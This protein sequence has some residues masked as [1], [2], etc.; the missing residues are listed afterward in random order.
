MLSDIPNFVFTFGY[1]NASWTL[2][3][4]LVS[5]IPYPLYLTVSSLIVPLGE[6]VHYRHAKL[7]EGEQDCEGLSEEA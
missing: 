2:K 3:S 5:A 7:H 6:Q 1:A 4:D